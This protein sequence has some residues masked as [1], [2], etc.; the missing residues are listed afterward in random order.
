MVKYQYI[1]IFYKNERMNCMKKIIAMLTT[2]ILAATTLCQATVFAAFSDVD[3]TNPYKK[4]ITTLSK[5][6]VIDGYEE[7]GV[8]LFKPENTVTRAEFTKLIVFMLGYQELTYSSYEFT[9]VDSSH[10]ARNFI[11]TAYNLGIIAGFGDG[12]F[13]PDS[14]VTYEQALKMVVCT[15]GYEQFAQS[16]PATSD[17]WADKY[18]QEANALNLTKNVSGTAYSAGAPRGV[19]AQVLYNALEIEMYEYNGYEWNR[20]DKT[21][22]NDYLKAKELKGT[23]VGVED[24]VTEDCTHA[25]NE[26][27]MDIMTSSGEE[28][29][30]NYSSFTTNKSDISK[31]L[32]NTITVYYRQPTA[33]D[34]KMLIIIDDET[35]KNSQIELNYDDISSLSGNTLK[36][37]ENNSKIKSIKLKEKDLTV[38]YNG[39]IVSADATVTL[40]NPDTKEEESFTRQEALEKWL[41]PDTEYTIYGDIKLTDSGNDGTVDMI[42]INNYETMVAYAAPTTADYRITDKLVTGNY[43][44]L[45]PQ[46]ANYTYTITKNGAEIP[47]T[48]IAA[49]DVILYAKSLDGSHYSLLVSNKT[50][51]GSIS[52]LSSDGSRM[53]INGTSYEVGD[54]CAAYIQEKNNKDLKVGIS[55]T[56]YLD[57]FNTAVFGT[58]EQTATVPYAYIA[59]AF[60]DYDEGGKA[61]ITAYAPNTSASSAASYPIKSRVKFNGSNIDS[62]TAIDRLMTS[63][64]YAGDESE[65]AEKIYGAGKTPNTTEYC[66]PARLMITNGEVTEI[67]VLTSDEIQTQNDDNEQIAK[68]RDIG[69]YT[70]SSN[71]FSQNGKTS[72]SVNSNT[73][74][75][76]VPS[77]RMQK[78]KYAKK[79]PSSAFTSGD[80]YYVEA[81]DINSSRI[82]GLVILYGNDGTL[83]TVKK[84]SDFSVVASL[85]ESIY[86][87]VRDEI[88]EKFDV[89]TGA[90]NTVKS[91][92]TYNATEFDNVQVG[93]VIQ[94]AYDSDNLIQGRI[95]NIKFADIAEVL[96]GA[97][98]NGQKFNWQAE[99]EPDE[100][101]NNQ[102]YKFDYRFKKPG[103]SDDETYTSSTLGTV[104]NSRAVMFNVSKVLLDEKKLYVTK[105]GF[106]TAEDGTY[107]I[108]DE[109]YEEI[110]VAP[111]TKIIRMEE[112]REEISR[113]AADTTTD[114]SI[115]DLKDAKNYGIDCS[116]ILVLMSKGNAKL[117]VVYN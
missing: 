96:D 16:L 86:S 116:K 83:T 68:C 91:W 47:V 82:A 45:D 107:Q 58:L 104:P 115:N 85:P 110:L 111:S 37:Y 35:S 78:K 46:A 44:I 12:I 74:V 33:N 23:L 7:N 53:T 98:N 14:P 50:V 64:S 26:D 102:K 106:E 6:S 63:A 57:A 29:L 97:E 88:V 79:A 113:Y 11:Q 38:R 48:S 8:S 21:L 114:M 59:D 103:T 66:Q 52:S 10:W 55:G 41:N 24:L 32:G 39:D 105:G 109:D 34:E 19:I 62:E 73:T 95:N 1:A 4:A 36:Y 54:T 75:L 112:D 69:Q 60:L 67:T 5:L 94:F 92:T 20:T 71:S 81:Y 108:D 42:Q 22:L 77:D 30:I 31:Y 3:D 72:F 17:N 18:I 99:Q 9:D 117:I 76:Y 2:V 87:D 51:K 15:L 40:I 70:Y 101:N 90:S 43:L 89:Y 49:N 27:E 25:L 100:S 56:F 13:A 61:Y 80:A 28:V 65:Y 93:D 84:D